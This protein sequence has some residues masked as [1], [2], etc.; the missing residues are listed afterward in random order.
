MTMYVCEVYVC[1]QPMACTICSVGKEC[2]FQS[3]SQSTDQRLPPGLRPQAFI[4][5]FRLSN[6]LGAS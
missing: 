3:F 6:P 1:Q 2:V 5:V 4:V